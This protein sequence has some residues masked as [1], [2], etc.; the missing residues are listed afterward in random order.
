MLPEL[1]N[2]GYIGIQ[3][4]TSAKIGR[5]NADFQ[6]AEYYSA[7]ILFRTGTGNQTGFS[8]AA[9]LTGIRGPPRR[10]FESE[11]PD[12]VDLEAHLGSANQM[13]PSDFII[14]SFGLLATPDKAKPLHIP[15]FTRSRKGTR[16]ADPGMIDALFGIVNAV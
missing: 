11:R 15:E 9:L 6:P 16:S 7:A 14:T 5:V 12:T 10:G 2:N 13:L 4:G 3:R 8:S 1:V